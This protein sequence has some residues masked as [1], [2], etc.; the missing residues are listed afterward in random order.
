MKNPLAKKPFSTL[1]KDLK[2]IRKR[3]LT[4][5]E[6]NELNRVFDEIENNEFRNDHFNKNSI[7]ENQ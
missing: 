3:K 4:D 1:A 2:E 7:L 5:K 6:V